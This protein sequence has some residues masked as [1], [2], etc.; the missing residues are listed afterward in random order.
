MLDKVLNT[1]DSRKQRSLESLREFL[2]IP[3]VSTKP[4]HKADMVKCANWL[5]DKFTAAKLDAK[6]M[7]TKGHPCVVAKNQHVAG[8]PTILFYGHYDVQPPE[9]EEAVQAPA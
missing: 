5:K 2:R 8:P 1:L 9:P 6:V 4:D 7:P 3:S